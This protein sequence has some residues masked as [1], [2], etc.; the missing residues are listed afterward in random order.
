MK[1]LLVALVALAPSIAL[2]HCGTDADNTFGDQDAAGGGGGGSSGG[3]IDNG[4][5]DGSTTDSGRSVSGGPACATANS[6]AT[7]VPVYL[8][9][10][11]DGSRSMD[12]HG[13]VPFGCDDR[14]T[15]YDGNTCFLAG[16]RE[17]DPLAPQRAD[18]VCHKENQA[19][20]ECPVFRGLTGKKW[21]AIRGAL[22]AFFTGQAAAPN[23]ALGVGMYLF[24]SSVKR[25][26]TAW[27]VP[28][29]MIDGPQATLLGARIAPGT[30][31]SGG[32]PLR[33]SVNGQAELLRAFQPAAPLLAEG[34]RAILLVTDGV[35]NGSSSDAEVVEAVRA[36]RSGTPEIVTAVI[37][38]GDPAAPPSN[39]YNET[40]LS[41]L[42]SEGGA[43]PAGCNPTWDGQ[44]PAGTTPC[45]VQVTPGEKD[46]AALQAEFLAAI[47]QIAL[48]LQSCELNLEATADIDPA[49]VNVVYVDGAG[50]ESQVPADATNGWT[51]DDPTN[52]TK[53]ILNGASCSAL[54]GDPKAK[55]SIVVGCPTGTDVR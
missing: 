13:N 50:A 19:I 4:G 2:L 14:D 43:A 49:K 23:P 32:T 22:Q 52:P 53:V 42:A 25:S 12:G 21:I 41:T 6:T 37:G 1:R 24:E 36:A 40:F 38:V 45:H 55:V 31:P 9:I 34:R 20:G 8:D 7:R 29:G 15:D 46:A 5:G 26:A 17:I 28:I 30:W 27:D 48:S 33:A 16:T 44:A 10:I 18:R 11:L 54:K 35:P 47:D 39:V 3:G 51:Y